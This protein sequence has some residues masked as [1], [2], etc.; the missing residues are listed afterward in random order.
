MFGGLAEVGKSS[1]TGA[2]R[3]QEQ[4]CLPHNGTVSSAQTT[5]GY[6]LQEWRLLGG[7]LIRGDRCKFYTYASK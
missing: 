6:F 3:C 2:V 7:V 5:I 4:R 1:E